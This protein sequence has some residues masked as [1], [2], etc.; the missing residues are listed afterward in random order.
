L[1]V[2]DE[3]EEKKKKKMADDDVEFPVPL[4]GS[5]PAPPLPLVEGGRLNRQCIIEPAWGLSGCS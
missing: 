3:Q 5:K 2:E 1:T 4:R